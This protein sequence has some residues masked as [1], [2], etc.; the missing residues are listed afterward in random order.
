MKIF[1]VI[2]DLFRMH[3]RAAILRAGLKRVGCPIL[4]TQRRHKL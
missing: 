1:H 4:T 3:S 2:F